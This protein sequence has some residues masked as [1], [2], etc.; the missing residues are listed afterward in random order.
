MSVC[1]RINLQGGR[2]LE[3]PCN[4]IGRSGFGIDNHG[5]SEFLLQEF[6][7]FVID[8]ITDTGNG[9][10]VSCF[11]GKNAA[12]QILLVRTGDCHQQI[13]LINACL[14]QGLMADSVTDHTHGVQTLGKLLNPLGAFINNN[15]IMILTT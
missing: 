10:A 2:K 12:Q 3:Q 6:Q 9:I 4:L 11:F 13:R 15:D 7:F 14:H 8:W 5:Q 1:K